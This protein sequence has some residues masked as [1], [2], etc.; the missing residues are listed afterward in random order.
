MHIHFFRFPATHGY[1]FLLIF[2]ILAYK[3]PTHGFLNTVVTSS[4]STE[5]FPI[6]SSITIHSVVRPRGNGNAKDYQKRGDGLYSLKEILSS[7]DNA[8]RSFIRTTLGTIAATLISYSTHPEN[9]LATESLVT[10]IKGPKPRAPLEALLPATRVK[11]AIDRA[12]ELVDELLVL[13]IKTNSSSHSATKDL[14]LKQEEILF[15]LSA[16]LLNPPTSY[17][18]S[19]YQQDNSGNKSTPPAFNSVPA[20]SPSKFYWK[21]YYKKFQSLPNPVTDAPLAVLTQVGEYDQFRK[22]RMK[23]KSLELSNPLRAALN[24]YTRQLQFTTESYVFTGDTE[25]RKQRIRDDNLPDIKSV[26][27]S[28]LDLR[29]LVR[30]QILNC[31]DDSQAELRYNIGEFRKL[32]ETHNNIG[33]ENLTFFDAKE[34]RILLGK[35]QDNCN[36][37][38]DFIP[39]EDAREALSVILKEEENTKS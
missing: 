13:N 16:L 12:V 36:D 10:P 11:R 39:E 6:T 28:D 31:W 8:R 23:Q 1:E 19:L 2:C 32:R 21:E 37:W 22:L 5:Y 9:G 27:V 25:D 18:I 29:D 20:A 14:L 4:F 26:I 17:M 15:N 35:A 24:Y 30:N 38:F 33:N 34:L 7:N 3:Y